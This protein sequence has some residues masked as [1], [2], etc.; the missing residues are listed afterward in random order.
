MMAAPRMARPVPAR[1]PDPE[2]ALAE[3]IHA[4]VRAALRRVRPALEAAG[5]SMSRFW[6]LH[7]VSNLSEPTVTAVAHHL[8]VSNPSASAAV[9]GLVRAGLVRRRRS[10]RD[11]RAVVLLLT[12]KGRRVEAR[13]LGAMVRLLG[14]AT[15]TLP[16]E[17]L[18]A[19]LG[20]LEPVASR[21]EYPDVT[22]GRAGPS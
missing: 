4:I 13:V 19:T 22:H 1:H 17:N 9:D 14:S 10:G 15:E 5:L 6:T 12:S 11:R 8:A 20:T 7:L 21:L 2:R 16:T 3:S 18:E